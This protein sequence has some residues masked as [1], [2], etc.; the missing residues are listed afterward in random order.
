[1]VPSQLLGVGTEQGFLRRMLSWT[2]S[3]LAAELSVYRLLHWISTW[4]VGWR[5]V[6][7]GGKCAPRIVRFHP[8]WSGPSG[9]RSGHLSTSSPPERSDSPALLS[10]RA[11]CSHCSG[12]TGF[13]PSLAVSEPV[14]PAAA[15]GRT[16]PPCHS[17]PSTHRSQQHGSAQF[18]TVS[19]L[20]RHAESA[21]SMSADMVPVPFLVFIKHSWVMRSQF[22]YWIAC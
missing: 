5:R 20:S 15:P 14:E 17:S 6:W 22:S 16:H 11:S 12:C 21:F 8:V 19:H 4:D 7:L 18:A 13:S 9:H 10:P 1:M 2:I 3:S